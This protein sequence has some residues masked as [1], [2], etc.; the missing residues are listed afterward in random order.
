MSASG[1]HSVTPVPICCSLRPSGCRPPGLPSLL[2]YPHIPGQC[3]RSRRCSSPLRRQGPPQKRR[4]APQV[5]APHRRAVERLHAGDHRHPAHHP[6]VRPHAGK[7]IHVPVAV[8]KDVLLKCRSAPGPAAVP[9]SAPPG[10]RWENPDREPSARD[11]P[12]AAAP[13]QA[14]AIPRAPRRCGTPASRSTAVTVA[15]CSSRAPRRNPVP[16][17]EARHRGK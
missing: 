11:A 15:R 14:Q 4:P 7:F 3:G 10:H 9:P 5:R 16:P 17:A 12:P 1:C 2:Q 13:R 6:D 8:F